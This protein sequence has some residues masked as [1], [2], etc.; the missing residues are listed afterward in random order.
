MVKEMIYRITKNITSRINFQFIF[1]SRYRRAIFDIEGVEKRFCEIVKEV[2]EELDIKL[3]KIECKVDYVY[4]SLEAPPKLS[5]NDIERKIK[6]KSSPILIN[7]FKELSK[8][9]SIWT[10]NYLVT[11]DKKLDKMEVEKFLEKQKRDRSKGWW[12]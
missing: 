4:I 6:A 2:C 1:C 10:R 7:E 9:P 11:T 3:Y 5:A 12:K 8:I